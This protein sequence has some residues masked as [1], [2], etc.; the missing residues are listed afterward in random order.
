[1]GFMIEEM[2]DDQR[3]CDKAQAVAG[4]EYRQLRALMLTG[5][6]SDISVARE[7]LRNEL[8]PELSN[9]IVFQRLLRCMSREVT[10]VAEQD[11]LEEANLSLA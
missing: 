8:P 7:K 1:M 9:D 5:P 6:V 11:L 10:R 2:L 4:R 3:L